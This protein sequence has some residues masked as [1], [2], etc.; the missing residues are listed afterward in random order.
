[1]SRFTSSVSVLFV[2]EFPNAFVLDRGHLSYTDYVRIEVEY[3]RAND[4]VFKAESDQWFM[5]GY[6]TIRRC[7]Q[8]PLM[9]EERYDE[10]SAYSTADLGDMVD[11]IVLC[12]FADGDVSDS[13]RMEIVDRLRSL[14]MI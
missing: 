13:E 8:N 4:P 10:D 1:M 7:D 11:N 3:I 6:R 2:R 5:D 12:L 9:H 14:V